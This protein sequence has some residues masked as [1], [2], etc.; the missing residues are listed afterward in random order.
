MAAAG[1]F[2]EASITFVT[3]DSVAV[4]NEDIRIGLFDHLER[5]SE[6][7][8]G[9]NTSYS[10]SSPNPVYEGLPGFYLELDVESADLATDLDIRRS[11]PSVTGRSIST[12]S[13]FSSIGNGP[14]VGY[15]FEP[16]TEYSVVLRVTRNAT[17]TLD[18]TAEFAGASFTVTDLLPAS[19]NIGMLAINA[20]SGAFG[21]SNVAGEANNGIDLVS[22]VVESTTVSYTHLT[23]PTIYS[24]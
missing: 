16:N 4:G 7:Q 24:V 9:Q 3:P 8:L 5:T 17:N 11:D 20:S 14:D 23:L 6:T 2:L 21:T 12:S 22:L 15:V 18:I 19:F 10:S 1:D 13:G